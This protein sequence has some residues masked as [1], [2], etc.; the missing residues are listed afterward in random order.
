MSS[1]YAGRSVTPMDRVEMFEQ[2]A[3]IASDPERTKRYAQTALDIRLNYNIDGIR[4][5][6]CW[7]S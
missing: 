6:G 5:K 3:R 1:L 7:A 4:E 2:L